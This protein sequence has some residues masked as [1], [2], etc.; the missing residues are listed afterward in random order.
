MWIIASLPFWAIGLACL[1]LSLVA[2][3]QFVTKSYEK[4]SPGELLGIAVFFML[5]AGVVLP[6]AAKVAS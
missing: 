3:G 1:V 2:F 6:I 5:V 4:N